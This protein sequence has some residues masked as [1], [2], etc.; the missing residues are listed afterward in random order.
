MGRSKDQLRQS[1]VHVDCAADERD[2]SRRASEA[3][4]AILQGDCFVADRFESES[5]GYFLV[6]RCSSGIRDLRALTKREA[7]VVSHAMRGESHKVIAYRLGLSRSW[8]TKLLGSVTRKLGLRSQAQLVLQ[9]SSLMQ[10]A[11][12]TRPARPDSAAAPGPS[13]TNRGKQ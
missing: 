11:D 6:V 13:L 3:W 8:V 7:D 5:R 12:A 4:H 10:F 1:A 2:C 9:L